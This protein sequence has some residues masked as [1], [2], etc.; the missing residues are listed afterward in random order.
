MNTHTVTLHEVLDN[1]GLRRRLFDRA[2]RDRRQ[3]I[4]AG[5]AWLA[6]QIPGF[7]PAIVGRHLARLG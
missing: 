7:G 1:P 3:S 2:R 4:R 6:A 5:V